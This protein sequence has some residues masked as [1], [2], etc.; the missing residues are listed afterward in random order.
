MKW[1]DQRPNFCEGIVS[2]PPEY[3]NSITSLF[4]VFYGL[5][6]LFITQN[7]NIIIRASSALLAATGIGSI[8][9]HATLHHGWGQVDGLPML[10][11]SY[12]GA[13]QAFDISLYKCLYIDGKNQ[14]KY[15]IASGI[16][17]FVIMCLLCISLALSV[18]DDTEHW[19]SILFL[20]PEVSIA[21]A[22]G[23]IKYNFTNNVKISVAGDVPR[24]FRIMY[25]GIGSAVIAAI[26]WFT[27]E[28]LCKSYP[29]LRFLYA[30]GIWHACISAGMYFLMQFLVFMYS[31]YKQKDPYFKTSDN[32]YL[33]YFYMFVP[34]VVLNNE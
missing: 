11:A 32:I 33:K 6:G 27:T 23:I 30:H 7:H 9:Y 2:G 22:V 3:V 28:S 19:F 4:L 20:I 16:L 21:I 24:A 17:A 12:L 5:A 31:Y 8:A 29:W 26:F 10:I 34:A 1:T 13:Y 25:V 15:E 14:R 18:S